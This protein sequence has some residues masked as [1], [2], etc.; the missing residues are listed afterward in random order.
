MQG[1]RTHGAQLVTLVQSAPSQPC[2]E[3]I[4]CLKATQNRSAFDAEK[5][6][7]LCLAQEGRLG[8]L[9]ML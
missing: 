7:P 1:P 8:A 6:E 2:M 4:L 5:V 3:Q 9:N